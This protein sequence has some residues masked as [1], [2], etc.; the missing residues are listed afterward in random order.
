MF[1]GGTIRDKIFFLTRS[2]TTRASKLFFTRENLQAPIVSPLAVHSP[3][4]SK[5]N[6]DQIIRSSIFVRSVDPPSRFLRNLLSLER[7]L[8]AKPWVHLTL[9]DIGTRLVAQ[10]SYGMWVSG[11][12][13]VAP[14]WAW[15]HNSRGMGWKEKKYFVREDAKKMRPQRPPGLEEQSTKAGGRCNTDRVDPSALKRSFCGSCFAEQW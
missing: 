1:G 11:L 8:L 3:R 2:F 12:D 15:V 13:W 14:R 4:F 7:T 5:E 10:G 9:V 6:A